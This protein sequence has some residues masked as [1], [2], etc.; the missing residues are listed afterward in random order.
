MSNVWRK[1]LVYLGLVEEPEPYGEPVAANRHAPSGVGA[2][3]GSPPPATN[4]RPLRA[5]APDG[6]PPAPVGL[7]DF[8]VATDVV[9]VG[10]RH[11]DDSERVAATYRDGHPV[12]FDL[13]DLDRPTARRVLDF[14][15]G[16]TYALEGQ[17]TAAGSLAFL[18]V[19]A[20]VEV[21]PAERQRL[22][23]LGYGSAV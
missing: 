4:V 18:L 12:L 5:A 21:A 2:S 23:S 6:T 19:P 17:L 15:S 9:V 13:S 16:V 7:L 3:G 10:V 1:T 8:E 22:A 20:G 11:F 14:V